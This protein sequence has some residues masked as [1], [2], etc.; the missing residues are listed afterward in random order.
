VGSSPLGELEGIEVGSS[1]VG[2]E[3]GT[4]DGKVAVGISDG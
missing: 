3:L 2:T 4:F 1:V